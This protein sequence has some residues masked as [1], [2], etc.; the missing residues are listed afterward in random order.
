MATHPRGQGRQQ[1]G[2]RF[3]LHN[4]KMHNPQPHQ[5]I[6]Y[7][8]YFLVLRQ[9]IIGCPLSTDWTVFTLR[10]VTL[11]MQSIGKWESSAG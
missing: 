11:C 7:S 9:F 5:P 8:V 3:P 10:K 1:Q 2:W 4:T 6:F